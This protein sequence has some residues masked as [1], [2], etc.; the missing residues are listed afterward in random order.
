MN[1]QIPKEVKESAS[2]LIDMYG[3]NIEYFG[4]YQEYVVYHYVFPKN[5]T[6]GYPYVFLCNSASKVQ[7]ITGEKALDILMAAKGMDNE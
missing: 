5:T 2:F 7:K 3:D 4:Q 6:T 1:K